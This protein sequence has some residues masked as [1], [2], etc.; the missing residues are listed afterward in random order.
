MDKRK[1]RKRGIYYKIMVMRIVVVCFFRHYF[2][3]AAKGFRRRSVAF[4]CAMSILLALFCQV[5]DSLTKSGDGESAMQEESDRRTGEKE[6]EKLP[7]SGGGVSAGEQPTGKPTGEPTSRPEGPENPPAKGPEG[8][9]TKE[10][11]NPP[12]KQPEENPTKKPENPLTEKQTQKPN[13][14]P[15]GQ[16]AGSVEPTE[17]PIEV[18]DNQ[19]KGPIISNER[20]TKK[21]DEAEENQPQGLGKLTEKPTVEPMDELR[22]DATECQED[23]RKGKENKLPDLPDEGII[24]VE[25]PTNPKMVVT[26]AVQGRESQIVSSQMPIINRSDFPLKVDVSEAVIDI[27][28]SENDI[29][30]DCSMNID[31][32]KGD[33]IVVVVR[34]LCGGVNP[35]GASFCLPS[36]EV[37][38]MRF[39]GCVKKGTEM[40]WNTPGDLSFF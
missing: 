33:D 16:P 30:K 2:A 32:L 28:Q 3:D 24:Q 20:P 5:S 39:S 22:E 12:T 6:S 9:P 35:I 15:T 38:Y 13:E 27:R 17:K 7:V 8:I 11:Q 1:L 23:L 25:L 36:D 29:K 37:A 26:P 34:N 10:P 18:G 19:L 21:P 4:A 31:I 40:M 14:E